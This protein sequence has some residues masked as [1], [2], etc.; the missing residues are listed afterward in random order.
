[1]SAAE[2][3]VKELLEAGAHFGHQSSRWNPKMRPFIFT[4][5]GGIHILDLDQTAQ[6]I[7][8]ACKYVTDQVALGGAVLFVGTKKQARDLI[9]V[10]SQRAGQFFV[11]IRW[12]G[13]MLTNFK[14]IKASIDRL[15]QLQKRKESPEFEKLVKKE[16]LMIDRDIEKLERNLSGIRAMNNLPACVFIVDPKKEEIAKKEAIRLK[17]PVIAMLDSNCD[18]TGI[19]YLIA[20][21]DDAIRSIQLVTGA[22]AEAC[23]EGSLRRQEALGR[24]TKETEEALSVVKTGGLVEERDVSGATKKA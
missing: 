2:I 23:I 4:T 24:D 12:L 17:I 14:T 7:K 15:N 19:D 16:R 3:S 18:P 22:I 11:N 6:Q 9:A 21:N 20:A 13:G 10:E 8:K 5:K 1:M